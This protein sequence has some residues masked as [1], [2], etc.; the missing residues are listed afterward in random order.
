MGPSAAYKVEGLCDGVPA[1]SGGEARRQGQLSLCSAPTMPFSSH[2]ASREEPTESKPWCVDHGDRLEAMSTVELWRALELG[3]LPHSTRVWREGIECW[4]PAGEV[5]ALGWTIS[6]PPPRDEAPALSAV[7]EAPESTG[8]LSFALTPDDLRTIAPRFHEGGPAGTGAER[9]ESFALGRFPLTEAAAAHETPAPP[10]SLEIP[11]CFPAIPSS[12]PDTLPSAGSP[13][14]VAAKLRPARGARDADQAARGRASGTW[15]RLARRARASRG[16][17][18]LAAGSAAL[19]LAL[20]LSVLSALAP[21][22]APARAAAGAAGAT[23]HIGVAR[24][25]AAAAAQVVLPAPELT[26][27][28]GAAAPAAAGLPAAAAL[29]DTAHAAL[30][31]AASAEGAGAPAL[32]LHRAGKAPAEG[33][34]PASVGRRERGQFR[35]RRGRSEADTA[36]GISYPGRGPGSWAGTGAIERDS[37]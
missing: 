29:S 21:A 23:A 4:T 6:Q 18:S 37:R 34:K 1:P 15:S 25:V 14:L 16:A 22:R 31:G 28:A 20:G 26:G 9:A 2:T 13:R 11:S 5:K 27:A 3:E 32:P 30:D 19:V 12:P 36:R 8:P 7:C 10:I 24:G 33:A 35:L 17:V